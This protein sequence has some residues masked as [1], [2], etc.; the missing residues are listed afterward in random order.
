MLHWMKSGASAA[1]SQG[2][3]REPLGRV[4]GRRMEDN[5]GEK[6]HGEKEHGEKKD[7]ERDD[8]DLIV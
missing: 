6:E 1:C 5:D 8:M 3:A 4:R 2:Q 7:G